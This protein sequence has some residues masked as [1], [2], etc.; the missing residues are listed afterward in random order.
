MLPS[1]RVSNA[2]VPARADAPHASRRVARVAVAQ[3]CSTNDLEANLSVCASLAARA[4]ELRC[5][6]LFLP[7][8]FS[9]ISE[10]GVDSVATAE[11]LSGRT[12]R[13]CAEMARKHSIWMS[14]GGFAERA[15]ERDDARYN[16]HVML[17]PD[18]E[19]HGEPYRK[20]H[21]FDAEGVGP[22]GQGLRESE[23]TLP[24]RELTSHA[25]DFG[26]VGVSICYDVRFP[27]VYQCLRFEH[28]AD[29]IIV[30][31]AF[32]KV[33]GKAHWETLLRARAIETQ[34]YVVAAAQ[35]G[36]HSAT[37]ESHGHAMIV[38]PWGEVIAKLDDPDEG[39]GIAVADISLDVVDAVR[40]KMPIASHRRPV[41]R[42][43]FSAD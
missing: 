28:G 34:C 2:S 9:R 26:T 27:D 20:I 24:G 15:D 39:V 3:M 29:I 19:I 12:V 42:E 8:A 22:S 33:T 21:L 11:A 38:D 31:S 37:R 17:G 4:A 43:K 5:V 35:A 1:A 10:R 14:L 7:E 13:A 6:A 36:R 32:T 18:G 41:R 16:T 30:P 25:T 23:W 40:A